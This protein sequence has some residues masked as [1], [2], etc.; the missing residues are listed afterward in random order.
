MWNLSQKNMNRK[1]YFLI[2][3]FVL[4]LAALFASTASAQDGGE[5]NPSPAATPSDNE[6]NAVAKQMFCPVCE[7]IPLDVCP[8]TACHEWREL[9]R[10]KLAAGWTEDQI[11]EYFAAQYGDRVLAEPPQRGLNLLVYI[12][13]VVFFLGGA[14][15]LYNVLRPKR[16]K[17]VQSTPAGEP[18]EAARPNDRY[19]AEIEEELR[20][21]E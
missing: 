5:S 10:E 2:A 11:K 20:K 8:T 3:F 12:L 9:I 1:N 17:A 16:V 14:V 13:P 19:L 15:V 7:N 4:A 6:V 21:K 18:V